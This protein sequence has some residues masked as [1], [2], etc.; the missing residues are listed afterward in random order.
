MRLPVS[1]WAR[2]CAACHY[3]TAWPKNAREEP[4]DY[5]TKFVALKNSARLL[6]LAL[7]PILPGRLGSGQFS[8]FQLKLIQEII[9]LGVFVLFN[10]FYFGES[11]K[12]NYAVA[13][14]LIF[15]AVYFDFLP[16]QN[17]AP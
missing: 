16:A 17:M 3:Y 7:R 4:A 2:P 11:L 12:W 13:A 8:K 14:A 15:G 10:L 6:Q 1:S 5:S 9:T